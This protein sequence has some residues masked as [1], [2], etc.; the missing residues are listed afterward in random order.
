MKLDLLILIGVLVA[1]SVII[2]NYLKEKWHLLFSLTL[3]IT[4]I[5]WVVRF[6]DIPL[7]NISTHLGSAI[8]GLIYGT[9]AYAL[10]SLAIASTIFIPFAK[11]FLHDERVIR[12]NTRQ[13]LYKTLVNLPVATIFLEEVIFRGVM[14]AL[15]MQNF[16]TTQSVLISSLLF[17][18]WHIF[19]AYTSTITNGS[20]KMMKKPAIP[21]IA[22]TVFITFLAGVG[23]S[24][25]RLA[26]GS[27]LA[28][29]MAHYA[30]NS[31]GII[32]SWWLHNFKK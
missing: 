16:S 4:V 10:I 29:M 18:L 17:G 20:I 2:N 32:A 13:F 25:L 8:P 12:L 15:L 22:G 6:S 9:I 7:G 30:T 23:F 11:G 24:W 26:S 21:V 14:L 31:G 27:I 5:W 3:S 28:P 19:P 1:Y